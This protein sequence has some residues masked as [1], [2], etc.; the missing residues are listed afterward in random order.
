MDSGE[1]S[2]KVTLWFIMKSASSSYLTTYLLTASQ[3]TGSQRR[4]PLQISYGIKFV[5]FN[6]IKTLVI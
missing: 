6:I 1:K 4:V 3:R 5:L 2:K